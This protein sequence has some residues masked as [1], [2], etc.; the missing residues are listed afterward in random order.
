[1]NIQGDAGV[2]LDGT[3]GCAETIENEPVGQDSHSKLMDVTTVAG[4]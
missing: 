3:C 4:E 1:M 2:S